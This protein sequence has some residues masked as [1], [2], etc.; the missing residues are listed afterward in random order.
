MGVTWN[1]KNWV[2]DT[3]ATPSNMRCVPKSVNNLE[4]YSLPSIN[5][6]PKFDKK[7]QT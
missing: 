7:K 3:S 4:K 6:A 2:E 1:N 5:I